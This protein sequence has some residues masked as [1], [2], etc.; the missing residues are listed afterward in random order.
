MNIIQL[1]ICSQANEQNASVTEHA[2]IRKEQLPYYLIGFH[3]GAVTMRA[4][5]KIGAWR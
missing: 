2:W 5:Q 4:Y 3:P 1:Q